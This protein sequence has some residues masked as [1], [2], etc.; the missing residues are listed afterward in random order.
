MKKNKLMFLVAVAVAVILLIIGIS[1]AMANA[2]EVEIS[3]PNLKKALQEVLGVSTVTTDRLDDLEELDLSGRNIAS[4]TGLEKAVNLRVLSLRNNR[5][6]DLTPLGSLSNLQSLDLCGNRV[7]A[8]TPLGKLSDLRI[9]HLTDN[10]VA[11]LSPVANLKRLQFVF[12]ENNA[13][14][15]ADGSADRKVLSTMEKRGIYLIVGEQH[16]EWDVSSEPENNTSSDVSSEP[17]NNTSS[18]VSSEPENNTSSDVSSKPESNTS[19][20]PSSATPVVPPVSSPS[21]DR[22]TVK[23]GAAF[24]LNQA[25]AYLTGVTPGTTVDKLLAALVHTGNTLT[26][27]RPDG[28]PAQATDQIGTGMVVKMKSSS[29]MVL[30]SYT[31][32]IYGDTN[33]DGD[34]DAIDLAM[35]RQDIV[36][37]GTVLTGY[38]MAAGNLYAQLRSD[39]SDQTIDA[40]DLAV[41]RQCI[42]GTQ[43]LP[44]A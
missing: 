5:I 36:N 26:I 8:L 27:T 15:L 21:V 40:I 19:S 29:G 33:G 13:L 12:C 6:T 7:S 32:V 22:L 17:E 3:D 42:L 34:I 16:P 18:D 11:D 25:K 10:R 31:V 44:Q 39:P 41:M 9:L 43:T 35:I 30:D 1:N 37:N 24:V 28:T 38:K 23:E 14:D 4:L 20:K 2:T